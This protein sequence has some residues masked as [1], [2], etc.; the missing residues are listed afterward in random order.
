MQGGS[1]A[2]GAAGHNR[3]CK[4]DRGQGVLRATGRVTTVHRQER[5]GP[6]AE[7]QWAVGRARRMPGVGSMCARIGVR[8]AP[9]AGWR[10]WPLLSSG[11]G[12]SAR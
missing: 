3:E 1:W 11:G 8:G 4:V 6:R 2:G 9:G 5:G 10:W 12:G 7:P